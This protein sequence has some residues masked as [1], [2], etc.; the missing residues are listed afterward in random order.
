M[1]RSPPAGYTVRGRTK[2]AHACHK[3]IHKDGTLELSYVVKAVPLARYSGTERG[4]SGSTFPVAWPTIA[5]GHGQDQNGSIQ[6]SI[7]HQERKTGKLEFARTSRRMRPAMWRFE[8][9]VDRLI[10]FGDKSCCGQGAALTIGSW[11]HF[12]PKKCDWCKIG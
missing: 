11:V 5:V 3:Q 2:R 1:W 6:F 7:N 12:T 9:S 4:S 10:E 8:D